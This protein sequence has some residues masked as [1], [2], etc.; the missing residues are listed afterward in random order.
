MGYG[1][2]TVTFENIIAT[3]D[4]KG[5]VTEPEGLGQLF[6][7]QGSKWLGSILYLPQAASFPH[8]VLFF[9][10]TDAGSHAQQGQFNP[11][12][13]LMFK[14]ILAFIHPSHARFGSVRGFRF[15]EGTDA[16]HPPGTSNTLSDLLSIAGVADAFSSSFPTTRVQHGRSIA[17]AIGTGKSV[18]TRRA[19]QPW[20]LQALRRRATD[21]ARVVALP[22]RQA[23]Q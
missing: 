3:W 1:Q 10:T 2:N 17:E 16:G 22:L 21:A 12:S 8:D 7:T 9:G 11:T 20:H 5:R 6:S 18:W 19:R 13:N 14:H 23:H 4:T 15:A